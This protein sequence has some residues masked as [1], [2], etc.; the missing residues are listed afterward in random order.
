LKKLWVL[1]FIFLILTSCTRQKPY[2]YH[3]EDF[4]NLLDITHTPDNMNDDSKFFFTDRGAWF[5]FAL[6]CLK[7]KLPEVLYSG[8]FIISKRK[9]LGESIKLVLSDD[10]GLLPAPKDENIKYLPG[11]LNRSY[12]ADGVKVE[13]NLIFISE[14][15]ALLSVRIK[16]T[17]DEKRLLS[18]VLEQKMFTKSLECDILKNGII[19]SFS[20][21]SENIYEQFDKNI[22]IKTDS[23]GFQVK[24]GKPFL[25]KSR[26]SVYITFTI[27]IAAR[28]KWENEQNLIADA[29]KNPEKYL[30]RN[31]KLWNK[32]IGKTL[33]SL[34]EERKQ[35]YRDVAVK[36]LMT[37]MV[38][39]R[40]PYKDLVHGGFF[41]SVMINY[42]D[43]FWAWD[44]WKHSA[45]MAGIEPDMAKEQIRAMFDYQTKEGMVPDAIYTDKRLNNKRDTKP[46]LAG[47]AVWRIYEEEGDQKFLKEMYGKLVLY[48]NWWYKFRDHD[49]DGLCEYGS[50]DGTLTAAKWESGMDD[51]VRFDKTK[52]L[53]NGPSSW[54]M[55]Q[56]SVCLNSFLY[57]E[58]EYLSKIA[59][60]LHILKD[61]RKWDKEADEL[62][63]KIRKFMF[64]PNS[65]YFYDTSIDNTSLIKVMGSEGW[66]PLWA[67]AATKKQAES[68]KKI[69][70][71]TLKFFTYIPLP[72]VAADGEQFMSGYWRGPVWLDQVYF[73]VSGLRKYGYKAFADSIFDAVINNCDGLAQDGTIRE[74]YDPRNGK[75]LKVHYFSWS[76]AS[77]LLMYWEL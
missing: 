74:N 64:D 11:R 33:G 16:N 25:V 18:S 65:G 66:A 63:I 44:S 56:E 1:I 47:W 62:K 61:Q 8:P 14:S 72:T 37:L 4:P 13:S 24:S 27:T 59:G 42:F 53:R 38:N 22:N 77:I 9:W 5:G 54:S 30:K 35:K 21:L 73:G 20:Q 52:M 31:K 58:K 70:A 15:T 71:D 51:A 40:A 23:S 26:Q 49:Q 17:G 76:A 10:K 50:T 45:A 36:S 60:V 3:Q 75:G 12:M 48:H 34:S 43:G 2:S 19:V 69:M 7:E 67:F 57:A 46:P 68:V 6:P 41:P 55:D 39:Y 29:L 28:E 32:Y